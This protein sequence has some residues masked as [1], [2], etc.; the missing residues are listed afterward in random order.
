MMAVEI[1]RRLGWGIDPVSFAEDRLNFSADPWQ[2]QLLRSRSPSVMLNCCR[3]SGKS[4]TAAIVA[5]HQAIYDP[6]WCCACLPVCGSRGSCL[7]R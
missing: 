5:L 3:Q 7:P 1:G 6:V 4:T 2:R